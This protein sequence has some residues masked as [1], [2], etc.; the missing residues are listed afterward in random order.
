MFIDEDDHQV[1][2]VIR[3]TERSLHIFTGNMPTLY[4][5]M[6]GTAEENVLDFGGCYVVLPIEF[7]QY[8]W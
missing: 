4:L 6:R 2:T 7:V 1:T 8:L 3:P 5:A